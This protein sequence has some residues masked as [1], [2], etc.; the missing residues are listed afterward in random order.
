MDVQNAKAILNDLIT[1]RDG[2]YKGLCDEK[3]RLLIRIKEL[4]VQLKDAFLQIDILNSSN[5]RDREAIRRSMKLAGS[6]LS[7]AQTEASEKNESSSVFL[8]E[9]LKIKKQIQT[10]AVHLDVLFTKVLQL[11]LGASKFSVDSSVSGVDL[12]SLS[13]DSTEGH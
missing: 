12:E 4:D 10:L 8:D 3:R 7:R 1:K 6:R 9:L 2:E 11:D 5:K 13:C